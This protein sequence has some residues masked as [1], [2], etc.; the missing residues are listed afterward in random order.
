MP[1]RVRAVHVAVL[2][3]RAVRLRCAV[4]VAGVFQRVGEALLQLGGH[5]RKLKAQRGAEGGADVRDTSGRVTQAGDHVAAQPCYPQD[6]VITPAGGRVRCGQGERGQGGG[7]AGRAALVRGDGQ[8]VDRRLARHSRLA[9]GKRRA[10]PL[11]PHRSPVTA[12][13]LHGGEPSPRESL[14]GHVTQRRA[15]LSELA[16]QRDR[17]LVLGAQLRTA[18]EPVDEIK[19]PRGG[20]SGG[21]SGG[22]VG[23]RGA[24]RLG[25]VGV[26]VHLAERVRRRDQ[27]VARPYDRV[28]RAYHRVGATLGR[29]RPAATRCRALLRHRVYGRGPLIV[30]ARCPLP[31]TSSLSGLGLVDQ[32]ERRL[33]RLPEG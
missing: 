33:G 16:E 19:P 9:E 23:Q 28:A 1:D 18:R 8:P 4:V 27:R 6:E 24:E 32:V 14:P 2:V 7:V 30:A 29:G 25:G 21:S 17:L 26:G 20:G 10:L 31:H 11:G 12:Q 15:P 13:F 5:H 3:R 22:P